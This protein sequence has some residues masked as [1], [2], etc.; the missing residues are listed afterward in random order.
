MCKTGY[1]EKTKGVCE[2]CDTIN[3]GC[4]ECHYEN[5]YLRGYY[6]FKRK[7][8]F[9]CDQCDNG[10]LISEDGTCHHCST[11][12]FENCKNCGVD[13]EHDNEIICVECQPGYF[14]ND[15]GKC[16]RCEDNKI[17]GKEN[18]C[19][20]C[21]DIENGGIEG[22]LSCNNVNNTPQCNLLQTRIYFIKG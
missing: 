13:K 19:I 5:D 11:L 21:D 9:S 15:Q 8:R 2:P 14:T 7:R 1:I 17:R 10:Y 20:S 3:D 18:T 4:I 16:I 22:C 6:G 12:G